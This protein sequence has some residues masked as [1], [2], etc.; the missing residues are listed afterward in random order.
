MLRKGSP[1]K[2]TAVAFLPP[3]PRFYVFVLK[4]PHIKQPFSLQRNV[5]PAFHAAD[6]KKNQLD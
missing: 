6:T 1:V 5:L 4:L 2:N 3:T